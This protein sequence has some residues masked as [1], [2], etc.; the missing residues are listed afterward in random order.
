[1]NPIRNAIRTGAAR[2]W[3]EF[4]QSVRSPQDQGFYL[5]MAG[6]ILVFLLFNRNNEVELE[7]VT[8]M[9]PTLTLPGI[10]GALIAFSLIVGIGYA[11][12]MEREDGTL[13]RAKAVPYGMVGHFTGHVV[14][15]NLGTG[16]SLAVILIPSYF[17]FDGLI[18]QGGSGWL[19]LAWVIAL[20]SLATLP[21]GFIIGSLVPGVQKVGTW[22][23]FPVMALFGISGI[24]FPMQALWSWVQV[25]AQVFPIYWMGLG[26]RSAFLP[27]MFAVGE[28]GGSWRPGMTVAILSAWAIAGMIITPPVL[29]RMARRQSGSAVEAARDEAVQWVR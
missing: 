22:G 23:M 19:T 9:Y 3:T 29:R 4:K 12:A 7:G 11:V 20:G 21:F 25:V 10:L 5:F 14:S 8:I 27:D 1:M 16:P 24:F 28:I 26:M 13:L 15:A 6:A 17:I 2:G 18:P